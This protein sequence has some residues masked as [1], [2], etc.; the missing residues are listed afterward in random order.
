MLKSTSNSSQSRS[1][2][3]NNEEAVYILH[4]PRTEDSPLY[5]VYCYTQITLFL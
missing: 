5:V 2:C 3:I 4:Y 1:R